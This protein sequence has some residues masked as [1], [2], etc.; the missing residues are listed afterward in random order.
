MSPPARP[1]ATASPSA[2]A[3]YHH[4]DLRAA[5]L[6]AAEAE[7]VDQGVE[8]FSLRGV[9]RRAGVSHAAPAHHFANVEALLTALAATSFARFDAAMHV[10]ARAAADDPIERLVAI[11]LAYLTYASEHPA[12]FDLQFASTRPDPCDPALA[13]ASKAAYATL[14]DTVEAVLRSRGRDEA[15]RTEAIATVWATAHGLASLFARRGSPMFAGATPQQQEAMF[16]RIARRMA[17]SL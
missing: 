2:R 1:V 11:T 7:I 8:K 9:A 17:L 13:D 15:T 14:R 12:M 4:G 6:A 5:L 16:A 10:R 3:A